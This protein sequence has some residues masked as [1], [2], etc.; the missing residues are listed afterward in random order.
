MVGQGASCPSHLKRFLLTKRFHAR[1]VGHIYV[2][3]RFF[4]YTSPCA[5]L[6]GQYFFSM[7]SLNYSLSFALFTF[8]VCSV[9]WLLECEVGGFV[10]F[11][12]ICLIFSTQP[13]QQNKSH[14]FS[15]PPGT[16]SDTNAPQH[17]HVVEELHAGNNKNR[18]ASVGRIIHLCGVV[19]ARKHSKHAGWLRVERLNACLVG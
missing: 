1:A 7:Y 18:T 6:C 10:R 14:T 11:L 3:R 8:T 15:L 17:S 4:I 13:K 12:N 2:D 16:A 9:A 19:T 5:R